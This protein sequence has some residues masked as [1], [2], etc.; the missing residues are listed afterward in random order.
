MEILEGIAYLLAFIVHWRVTLSLV[1][2]ALISVLLV[3]EISWL[4]GLQGTAIAL[5]GGLITGSIWESMA[6]ENAQASP[7]PD[8]KTSAGV[9]IVLAVIAGGSWGAVSSLSLPSFFAGLVILALTTW[10]WVWYA[11]SLKS[12]VS[13]PQAVF[14]VVCAGVAYPAGAALTHHFFLPGL[15]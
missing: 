5:V 12:W 9:A 4:S 15:I 11:Q 3:H 7:A 8:R 10:A 6:E 14:Y 13:R 1:G 2:F